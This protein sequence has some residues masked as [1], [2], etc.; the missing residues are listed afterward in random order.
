MEKAYKITK[1]KHTNPNCQCASC[2]AKRGEYKGKNNPMYGRRGALSGKKHW[3][4]KD[5]RTLKKHYCIDCLKNGIKTE[6]SEY[7]H[8]RCGHCSHKGKQHPFYGKKRPKHSKQMIGKNNPHFGKVTHS[9]GSYYKEIWMGSTWEVAYA[10]YLDKNKIK[11][12]YEQETFDLDDTTYTPDFYL[13]ETDEYIEIKGWWRKKAL[14]KFNKFKKKYPE[15][16][17][18]VLMFKELRQRKVL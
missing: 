15:I 6:L 14:I 17:I 7:R 2:K 10:K 16:K 1:K 18:K 5:G 3:C 4:Y 12:Q 8:Q 11:W 13:P 9:K